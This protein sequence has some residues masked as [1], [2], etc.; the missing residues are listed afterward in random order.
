MGTKIDAGNNVSRM[1]KLGN[2]GE[3]CA[4]YECFSK[5]VFDL[6]KVIENGTAF[7]IGSWGEA[8]S[9][10]CARSCFPP[11]SAERT[12][13]SYEAIPSPIRYRAHGVLA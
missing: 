12:S 6:S 11:A 5:H 7:P 13:V 2:I 9:E 10:L 3:T 8:E 4:H 1:A